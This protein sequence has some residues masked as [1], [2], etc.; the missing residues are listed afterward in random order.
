MYFWASWDWIH[1]LVA[2]KAHDLPSISI[3]PAYKISKTNENIF[4]GI[5]DN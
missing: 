4:I 3:S 1:G 2:C 5:E